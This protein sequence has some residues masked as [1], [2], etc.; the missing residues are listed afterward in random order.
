M[1]WIIDVMHKNS[2]CVSDFGATGDGQTLDTPS[3]QAA[4]DA[5]HAAGGGLVFVGPGNYLCTTVRLK[6]GVTL[7]LAEGSRLVGS[8]EV[9]AYSAPTSTNGNWNRGLLVIEDAADVAVVGPGVIDGAHAFDPTGEE[10]MRGPHT[11]VLS[12]STGVR[13]ENL[14][15]ENAA[16]YAILAYHTDHLTMRNCVFTGGWDG[17]HV[18]GSKDRPCK[19]VSITSCEFYTGD[20]AI[21]GWY[22]EDFV[23]SNCVINSSC[24]GIRVIGPANGLLVHDVLFYG[25]GR[26]PHRTNGTRTNMLV[27]ILIQPG[28]WDVTVGHTDEVLISNVTMRNVT[29]ALAVFTKPGNTVGRIVAERVSAYGVTHAPCSFESWA[30]S[31]IEHVT[32]RDV[33]VEYAPQAVMEIPCA[34][35][36]EP[37]H[38]TRPLPAW[39]VYA[40]RVNDLLLDRVTMRTHANESRPPVTFE[41]GGAVREVECRFDK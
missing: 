4:I 16:N 17:V 33:H 13:F 18:R 40:R 27:G 11:V 7:Q 21:A 39:G 41:T 9:T 15:I 25:P 29:A 8:T 37:R 14:R 20:D 1:S 36:T 2:Y 30:E 19:H 22:W 3:V 32:L 12:R 5:C 6:S 23:V 34:G 24:N 28:A 26:H 35:A 38:E 31:P 10:Q